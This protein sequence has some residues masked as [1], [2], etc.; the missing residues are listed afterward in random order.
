MPKNT[1]Q[2]KEARNTRD[3]ISAMDVDSDTIFG[4]TI[5]ALGNRR[6]RVIL[7]DSRGSL[8]EEQARIGGKIIRIEI[9]DIVIIKQSG[10]DYEIL[11]RMDKKNTARLQKANRIHPTLLLTGE[12]TAD[13]MMK[14]DVDETGFEFDYEDGGHLSPIPEEKDDEP[15][16]SSH[17][18][19]KVDADDIDIDAI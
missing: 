11:G 7:P 15:V 13:K 10:R 16:K 5:K 1:Q 19:T 4:K 6:F 2:K 18:T 9:N 14:S 3:A 17:S 8:R 12:I